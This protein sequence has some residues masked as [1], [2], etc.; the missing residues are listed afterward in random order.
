[1]PQT[2][3]PDRPPA[4]PAGTKFA[5]VQAAGEL[6]A[7]LGL[8]GT[9]TRAIADRAHSNIGCIHYYFGGKENLYWAAIEYVFHCRITE[10][11]AGLVLPR[12]ATRQEVSDVLAELV[13]R[14]FLA[15][16]APEVPA[17]HS[18]L[19]WRFVMDQPQDGRSRLVERVFR[20]DFE[21]FAGIVRRAKRHISDRQIRLLLYQ[22]ISQLIF[23]SRHHRKVLEE[24]GREAYDA[25]LLGE[26]ADH[27]ARSLTRML[28][29][30]D[31]SGR[32][33]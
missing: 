3:E 28:Q 14:R 15:S 9:R 23:Y 11:S 2:I 31:P 32:K 1:M 16:C 12:R 10:Q 18:G 5:L 21:R 7:E 19:L 33:D 29:L 20:P 27:V 30:P 26:I 8:K 25:E 24:L 17:W 6:F 4:R 13:R 22:L